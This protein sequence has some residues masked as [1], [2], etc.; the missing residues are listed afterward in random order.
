MSDKEKNM[1]VPLMRQIYE[2]S[3]G[4]LVWLGEGTEDSGPATS[5]IKK[6]ND[7]ATIAGSTIPHINVLSSQDHMKY[8]LPPP[9]TREIR[10]YRA[11]LSLL[12]TEWFYRAWVVQEV[13]VAKKATLFWGAFSAELNDLIS[14]MDFALKANLPLTTH[15]LANSLNLIL[16]I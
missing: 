12:E 15:P 2:G 7:A 1:Q 3:S 13:T 14:G 4:V 16:R 10:D 5:L 11:L 9:W 6:L 8:G